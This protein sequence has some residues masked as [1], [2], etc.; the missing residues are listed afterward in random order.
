MLRKLDAAFQNLLGHAIA[1]TTLHILRE[2]E[3]NL[4]AHPAVSQLIMHLHVEEDFITTT[5]RWASTWVA[6]EVAMKLF[7]TERDDLRTYLSASAVEADPGGIR[8]ILWQAL[9][10]KVSPAGDTNR[11]R[12]TW[13]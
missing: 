6:E 3:G 9:C 13:L 1:G 4:N 12:A 2:C 8:A 11:N 10:H 5:V 7:Q